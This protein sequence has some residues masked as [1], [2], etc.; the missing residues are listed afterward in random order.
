MKTNEL[1]VLDCAGCEL[2]S[3]TTIKADILSGMAYKKLP[4]PTLTVDMAMGWALVGIKQIIGIWPEMIDYVHT[5]LI[6]A[7]F[8]VELLEDAQYQLAVNR[9]GRARIPRPPSVCAVDPVDWPGLRESALCPVGWLLVIDADNDVIAMM[10]PE[11]AV[12]M[13]RLLNHILEK[14]IHHTS[15]ENSRYVELVL[16][17]I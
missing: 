13:V 6:D 2:L 15:S 17:M 14:N 10:E 1:P 8:D 4:R 3:S 12:T 11:R 5:T 7:G 9:T 16:Q